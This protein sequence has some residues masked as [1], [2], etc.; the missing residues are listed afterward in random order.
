[1]SAL[2]R[3][4]G[5]AGFHFHNRFTRRLPA[6]AALAAEVARQA[7]RWR[8]LDFAQAVPDLRYRLRRDGLRRALVVE[9]FGLYAARLPAPPAA[10]VLA[11][12]LRLVRGGIVELTDPAGRRCALALAALVRALQGERVHLLSALDASAKSLYE[13]LVPPFAALGIPAGCVLR[14]STIAARRE[15]YGC[16]VVCGTHR[17]VAQDYL[18]QRIQTGQGRGRLSGSLERL[19]AGGER[20]MPSELDCALVEDADLTMLDD[21][22]APV[23]IAAEVDQS[24]ERLLYE[25]ALELAR[26]LARGADYVVGDEGIVLTESA[27]SVLERLVAPLG[28]LWR[29]RER[30]EELIALA[31]EALHLFQRDV[32]YRVLNGHVLFP[33][34]PVQGETVPG[35]DE[36][37]QKLVEVK[38]GCPLSARK[39]VLGRLSVPRFFGR[40]GRLAGVCADARGLEAEF[41]ALYTLKTVRAGDCPPA[42]PLAYR[43]FASAEDKRAALAEFARAALVEGAG[44]RVAARRSGEI[45]AVQ[46]AFQAAGIPSTAE[47]TFG[48]LP[49]GQ[50]PG[51]NPR[52]ILIAELP[53]AA[54][55]VERLQRETGAQAC[56]V[57][58]SLDE[59]AVAAHLGEALSSMVQLAL[60]NRAEL[61]PSHAA[62]FARRAQRA[63]ERAGRGLRLEQKA[64]EQTL[65]DLLAFS[66]QL[67]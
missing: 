2:E 7:A 3:L 43:F 28:G 26:G 49:A 21:A 66:G 48:V 45:Q 18:R 19:S 34:R 46:A 1:M 60:R 39:E 20:L 59:E 57:F 10:P 64:R 36:E 58:L 12:A 42:V 29:A 62:W 22:H 65:D 25:Q 32:D 67:N 15:A 38:E 35:P 56:V 30:R 53:D 24:S 4:L 37:I 5:A 51:V 27:A 16:T 41:W 31:L 9:C 61:A 13:E 6:S 63:A 14:T 17:E 23:A 55:H 54:R 52:T 8:A 47:L 11:A 44:V 50:A 33:P 40:Y